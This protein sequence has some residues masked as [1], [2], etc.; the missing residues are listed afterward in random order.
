MMLTQMMTLM[1]TVEKDDLNDDDDNNE[2]SRNDV[3]EPNNDPCVPI[4]PVC[5][6]D[7]GEAANEPN[8]DGVACY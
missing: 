5:E 6:L 7:D 8:E 3:D 2:D 4:E 1:V